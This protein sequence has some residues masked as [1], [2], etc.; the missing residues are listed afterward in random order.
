MSTSCC[1]AISRCEHYDEQV[2]TA[3]LTE[4]RDPVISWTRDE[5]DPEISSTRDA[6]RCTSLSTCP[7]HWTRSAEE[8]TASSAG[9]AEKPATHDGRGSFGTASLGLQLTPTSE[10]EAA[11]VFDSPSI[12]KHGSQLS[13]AGGIRSQQHHPPAERKKIDQCV[14]H[15]EPVSLTL[16]H[17]VLRSRV[18]DHVTGPR[19]YRLYGYN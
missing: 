5:S 10:A 6:T 4:D 3:P 13:T 15:L 19:R 8:T 18:N 2:A 11:G 1:M 14:A 16:L 17:R 12:N 9:N 7:D